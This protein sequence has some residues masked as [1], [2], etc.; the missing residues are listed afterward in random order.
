MT[1]GTNGGI[2]VT[3]VTNASRTMLMNIDTLNW[4]PILCRTFGINPEILPQ[5]RSSSEI[6]GYIKKWSGLCGIPISGILGNQQAALLG[7]RCMSPGQAKNTYR[8]GC[9]LLYNTGTTVSLAK[10]TCSLENG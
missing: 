2:H 1:G 8:S 6:Y 5:I 9:F 7:Q 3:D 4:D 10:I